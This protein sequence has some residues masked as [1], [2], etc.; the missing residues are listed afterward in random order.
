MQNLTKNFFFRFIVFSLVFILILG[1]SPSQSASAATTVLYVK[2][3]G[4]AS[5]LC[6]T[7]ENA[8]DMQYAIFL[9]GADS[10]IWAAEGIY[11]PTAG[12]DRAATFQLKNGLAIYGGFA[13]TESNR[14]ERDWETNISVLSGDIGTGDDP[15]DNSYH[16]V[17]G[18]AT[19]SSAILDGFTVTGGNANGTPPNNSGGGMYNY[20]GGPS[21]ANVIFTSNT[22]SSNGGGMHNSL[23][24]YPSLSDVTFVDNSATNL[25]GGMYNNNSSPLLLNVTFADNNAFDGGGMYNYGSSPSLTSVTFTGNSA[26]TNGGGMNNYMLSYPILTDV[27][28]ESNTA[29]GA[30]G[31]MFSYLSNPVLT[32]VTFTTNSAINGGGMGNEVCVPSL[33]GVTFLG[34]TA[35]KGGGM[36]NS[37]A[38][39]S[40]ED[41]TFSG[42]T[43]AANGGGMYNTFSTSLTLLNVTF[44]GNSAAALGGGMYNQSS[45][46]GMTSVTFTGNGALE[47]GGM[48]NNGSSPSLTGVTFTTNTA[49]TNGGGM[50]NYLLSN[51]ILTDLTFVSNTAVGAGGGMYNQQSDPVLTTVTFS[52]NDAANGGGMGNENSAPVLSEV[53]FAGNTADRG[54]GMHNSNANPSL[55]DVTFSGNTVTVNGGGM[56]STN[57]ISPALLNVTFEGN[58]AAALGGGMYNLLSTP[59]LTSVTFTGNDALNGGGMYNNGSSP[60]LT[61]VTF[62][63]NV[64]DTDGGGMY[65]YLQSN[66]TLMDVSFES[67]TAVS[68]GGGLFNQLSD[69]ILSAVTF[70]TNEAANGGGMGNETSDPSLSEVTFLGNTAS[71]GG[72]LYNSNSN[73]GL[74]GVS[75]TGN[76][77]SA[78]GGGMYNT[79][80]TGLSLVNVTFVDNSAASLGGGIYNDY[81][82]PGLANITFIGNNS[83]YGA[84]IYNN[85]SNMSLSNCSF[86]DNVATTDGGGVFNSWSNPYIYNSILWGN[87]PGQVINDLHSNPVV[88]YSDLQGGCSARSLCTGVKNSDPLFINPGSGDLRLGETSPAIDAGDNSRVPADIFDLNNNGNTTEPLPYDIAGNSR[89]VDI[90]EIVDTGVGTAPIVDMGAFERGII[91][92]SDLDLWQT[93]DPINDPW[94]KVPGSYMDGFNMLL[95]TSVPF[96]YFD[97]EAITSNHPLADGFYPFYFASYPDGFFAYWASRDVYEGAPDWQGVMWEIITGDLPVFYLDVSGT[98]YNLVDGLS[99]AMA[100]GEPPLRIDGTYLPG[101]YSF[102]GVVLDIFDFP[103]DVL[104][105]IV[106]DDIPVADDQEVS[107]NEDIPLDITL[108]ATDLYPGNL[109]WIVV[110]PPDHGAL[111]GTAPDL[112]YTPELNY[113]GPDSFTFKVNDGTVDSNLATVTITITPVNDAPVAVDDA[114]T[115]DEDTDLVVSAPGVL[116]ND[117]DPEDDPLTAV[118]DEAPAHGELTLNANGSF[119][120]IPDEDYAGTDT[121]TYHANDGELDS[122]TVTVTITIMQVRF[123]FYLPMIIR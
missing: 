46:P 117:S 111:S 80:S 82:T 41:V 66:P 91:I 75:F 74:V 37:N 50:Y 104:V 22:A 99:Y 100:W 9:A 62:T 16:V 60:S 29:G 77:V 57:S 83:I 23:S 49:D 17:T 14:E 8:C 25:G 123:I 4:L 48:Y 47:G 102:S 86:Y 96:Y 61:G 110:T 101:A 105:N 51:P 98:V 69:P 36:H 73:P 95:D 90:P 26:L 114:Y 32:M 119:V 71:Q 94:V 40:L 87:T 121:F 115:T 88:T 112:T 89:F 70:N 107:T 35:S 55:E 81:S 108:T 5:G 76:T 27:T 6:D 2:P 53:T 31:G 64:A 67:N 106:F 122:N 30:G 63:T 45:T 12:S 116:G 113:N 54:G 97:T 15:G 7:W 72:G 33:S 21:L 79:Y 44:D 39:P 84:G 28:L 11:Y 20:Q 3:T 13:G 38:N 19:D 42:N 59:S 1:F 118:L 56:Y 120:Y 78:S 24:S 92:I 65:N 10:E 58:S 109:S 18:N 68:A 93:T 52:A 103:G 34:N 43:V 85:Y